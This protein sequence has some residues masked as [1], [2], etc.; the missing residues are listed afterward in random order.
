M[1][2]A[3]PD[4]IKNTCKQ[5]RLLCDG[6]NDASIIDAEKEVASETV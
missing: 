1:E 5:I 3:I 4:W 6:G 2:N